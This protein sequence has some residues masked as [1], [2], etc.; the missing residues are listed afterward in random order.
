MF[1]IT[2]ITTLRLNTLVIGCFL[3]PLFLRATPA[4]GQDWT[5][6]ILASGQFKIETSSIY[7]YT[8]ERFGKRLESGAIVETVE[9]LGFDFTSS[10]IGSG[11]FPVL[12][13]LENQL[14]DIID[15]KDYSV[16][17]GSTA[18]DITQDAV[19]IPL[20]MS[21][22]LLDNLTL[23]V[24]VPITRERTEIGTH[25]NPENSNV[26]ISPTIDNVAGV[27]SFLDN[28]NSAESELSNIIG[29]LCSS[30][31]ESAQCIEAYSVLQ[32][33]QT[34]RETLT[35]SYTGFGVFPLTNS[36]A[37]NLLK[38]RLDDLSTAHSNLGVNSFPATMPLATNLISQKHYL[39][40]ITDPS[41]GI[42]AVSLESQ[43][44]PW[45]LGD[46][47]FFSNFKMLSKNKKDIESE[48]SSSRN[49]NYLVG[50]GGLFR[51]GTGQSDLANNFVDVGN[52][53]G[54]NDFELKV[55]VNLSDVE[56]WSV[57]LEAS[58][59][60]Q[61]PT[62]I[63]RRIAPPHVT[64]PPSST[65]QLLNWTPGDYTQV[66][67]SPRFRLTRE[68]ALLTDTRY[69]NKKS[70]KYT[71]VSMP[72]CNLSVCLDPK[73]LQHETDQN[74]LEV[75]G[76]F[77]FSKRFPAN[78]RPLELHLLYRK[79]VWGKGG[80]TPKTSLFEFGVRL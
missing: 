19:R 10:N 58:Y 74:L 67:I 36:A 53:D 59:G 49:I 22:G 14:G 33:S 65:T 3:I 54:Q 72:D 16:V 52:G 21:V 6:P 78:S 63:T 39:S 45:T 1:I 5:N 50:V 57:W 66:R 2:K 17:L 28:L 43:L 27:N 62:T 30:G 51:L 69:F 12:S 18:T 79:A 76:G 61:R 42:D 68:L 34:F 60:I 73:A 64:F 77:I 4:S 24:T 15:E 37:G 35:Q 11:F 32:E 70:D 48:P 25:F 80:N 46:I 47:E 41:Y 9:P 31:V 20:T 13:K 44:R 56:L 71:M 38:L 8:S 55:F 29:D 26:G 7:L 40:L 75:G 23:G